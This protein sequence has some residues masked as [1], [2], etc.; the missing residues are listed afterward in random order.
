[1]YPK[2]QF[3]PYGFHADVLR[4]RFLLEII[5]SEPSAQL[6]LYQ[7]KSAVLNS[8]IVTV[9]CGA[10]NLSR[11]FAEFIETTDSDG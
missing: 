11:I 10:C 5:I 8:K 2:R 7:S 9:S 4:V 1:M 3:G 6:S